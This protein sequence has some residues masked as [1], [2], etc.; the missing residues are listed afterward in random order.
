[1][2]MLFIIV[3]MGRMALACYVDDDLMGREAIIMLPGG[4]IPIALHICARFN[5]DYLGECSH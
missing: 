2:A 1:M 4:D 3:I 5:F